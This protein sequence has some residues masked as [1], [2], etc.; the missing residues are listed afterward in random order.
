VNIA[1]NRSAVLRQA[2]FVVKQRKPL[3][4]RVEE[5]KAIAE[6]ENLL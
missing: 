5:K 2:G 1:S 4:K 3:A 6:N